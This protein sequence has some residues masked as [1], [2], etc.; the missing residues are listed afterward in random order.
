MFAL[1]VSNDVG[2]VARPS[3]SN[4]KKTATF[5]HKEAA[6]STKENGETGA[7][8]HSGFGN[9]TGLHRKYREERGWARRLVAD[10]TRPPYRAGRATRLRPCSL[11]GRVDTRRSAATTRPPGRCGAIRAIRPARC[12]AAD[13]VAVVRRRGGRRCPIRR[14][15]FAARRRGAGSRPSATP[16]CRTR[17]GAWERTPG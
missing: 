5:S 8:P 15:T 1:S 14:Q 4:S 13:R 17:G 9:Q 6:K 3:R 12:G 11:F 10:A 16:N 7:L 2:R